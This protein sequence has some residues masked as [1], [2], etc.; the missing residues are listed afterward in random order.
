MAARAS[1]HL[2][3]AGWGGGIIQRQPHISGQ[4]IRFM[5]KH[6]GHQYLATECEAAQSKNKQEV[7]KLGNQLLAKVK[8]PMC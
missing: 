6:A 2:T 5:S 3:E 7:G 4:A 1:A 8:F